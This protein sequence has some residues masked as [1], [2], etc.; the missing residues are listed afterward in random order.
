MIMS[1]LDR[2]L[3]LSFNTYV[4]FYTTAEFQH[5]AV[6]VSLCPGL[7]LLCIFPLAISVVLRCVKLKPNA[8]V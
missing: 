1:A 7:T 6:F 2:G 4:P 8:G 5:S 3:G